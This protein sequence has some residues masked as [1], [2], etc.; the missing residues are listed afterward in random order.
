MPGHGIT[1]PDP[2]P[3]LYPGPSTLCKQFFDS[4]DL[5]RQS[6]GVEISNDFT[7]NCGLLNS[8]SP[9]RLTAG[10]P[11]LPDPF[12]PASLQDL[13]H[14]Y[15]S[16]RPRASHRYSPTHG[17]HRLRFS[18]STTT[19]QPTRGCRYRDDRF[20]CSIP[21][22]A[23]SS[24][25]LYAGHHQGHTQAAP[26]LHDHPTGQSFVPGHEGLPVSMSSTSLSTPQQW[27]TH[28]RFSSPT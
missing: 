20:S 21:A 23:T 10:R 17:A 25:H 24:R 2:L 27:F 15:E 26:W 5:D 9:E 13:H 11:D 3:C 16:A 28:V 4:V 8:S 18:L 12:A 19:G 22:P 7:F 6:L 14:Y 1:G